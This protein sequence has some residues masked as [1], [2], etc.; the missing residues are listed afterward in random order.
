MIW[1]APADGTYFVVVRGYSSLQ[2]GRFYISANLTTEAQGTGD[3]NPCHGEGVT[4]RAEAA[5]I[6]FH[7]AA[8][9]DICRWHIVCPDE[10]AHV[11]VWVEGLDN[12][13]GDARLTAHALDSASSAI[14]FNL[15]PTANEATA[16]PMHRF[17]GQ[18]SSML[19]TFTPRGVG[20]TMTREEQEA[21]AAASRR[22]GVG[23][24]G[25]V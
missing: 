5:S 6:G 16:D 25:K 8:D 14:V 15:P 24:D 23:F 13:W 22:D 10:T 21:A 18:G 3:S 17:H 7:E 2:T 11:S 20:S 1:T 9:G 19:L 4:I 12:Q